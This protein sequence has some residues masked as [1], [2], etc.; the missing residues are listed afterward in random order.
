V[1]RFTL[2]TIIVLLTLLLV[3]GIWQLSLGTS[4]QERNERNSPP[5]TAGS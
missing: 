1:R 2:I 4:V 5:P 3:V